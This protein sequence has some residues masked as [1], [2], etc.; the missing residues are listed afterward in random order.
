[1]KTIKAMKYTKWIVI[2][3]C[4]LG[5]AACRQDAPRFRIGVAQCSDDSWRHKM[6]DEILREAMFYDGVSVEIRSAGDD[7]R[8]QAEDIHYF[9]DKGVD[10]LIISANE[11]APMTPIVEEV[12]QKGIPVVLVDRKILSDKYTAYIGADNYEIGRTVGNY[13][14]SSLKGK[15]NVVELTG[16]GGSTPAMERHQGFMAAISNFPDVKL[17]DKADAAWER[18]PAEVEMDSMLCRNPKIDA[19]YA[20]NDR[21]AP[22]AYQAAKKVGREKEM[23][24]VGIDA[25]PGK[26]NGLELVLDSVLDATFIY[27]TNGDKVLQLAM[28]ILEKKPYPRETVMN[29]A[30]VDRTNAHVMQLQTTHISELDQKIET[31]NG[32]IGGYLSRVATQQVVMYGGLAILLLVAGLLLVVYKSLRSKNRLNK[33]LSEQK[34]QLEEQRDKLEEQRDKLEEQRDKLEEQRDQLIQLSHQLEEATHAKLVFF[35]NI[36]HDFRTPLTLVADPVEH[37]LAD[38]TLSG[39]QHRMLMLIQR[40]VNIL[41][42]LVNQILDFRKYENGKMEYTPVPVDILSSFE[43]WNESFL[44]A[45]RKKHIHFSF[46]NMPDTDFRTLAD[47]EKL[48]RIYFNLLSNAFKFTPE[49]GKVTVRLSTLTEEDNRWIRFTVSNTGSMISAEHIRN[50]FDRFYKIDMH[51]AGS[52]IGLAL[53][54][55]FVELHG[56]TISVESDE[57]QGTVFT[58]DLPVRTCDTHTVEDLLTSSASFASSVSE[59]SSLNDALSIG[60]EEKPGKSYDP[61]KTSV[62]IIDDNADIRSYVHGLLHTDYTVIEAADGSEGIRK[63]MRYVPDL[64]ISDVMMPGID[65]IECCRRLKSELQTCHIPVIL[66]TACSLDEQRIQGYDGGADSY[67]SKPFSSQLLLARVRNLI[68]S[69]R[70]LKQFFGDGQTLAKEDVCDMDKDFVEKFKA[71]IDAKMGDSNL[72]VEDLGKDMGLSRVQLY[73]KIKSLTNYSPN[74]LLRI[75][76]LK[77]AASLLAS[78][79]MTVSE[80]GYEVGFSSPSYFTKCYKEQFGESPTDLLKRKG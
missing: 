65:G 6:N 51:H 18:G 62:L 57:K 67:I 36:S 12:Y 14:A 21:I 64:I 3:F 34:R 13:I 69:H 80:I 79:D 70:R 38:K 42:R 33:E 61:S 76:R 41:L 73:R 52:G 58:V 37:L 31:L 23:M 40:N 16:L 45:A 78:S 59:S 46:D 2:L 10:L 19:V 32:R 66:L 26:G 9:I 74:E 54:K 55:A 24:F 60:E 11:A 4:L 8:R 30:V 27:P 56:G 22:G 49:N 25:L 20:H 63:A 68:D 29:T 77:K 43:G 28:N 75:A 39:D 50:I 17:I 15:G 5:M 44:S 53:V 72:N 7:N 1:M 48:E 71:L 47:V 35:T